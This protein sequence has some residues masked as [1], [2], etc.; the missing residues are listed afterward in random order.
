MARGRKKGG[1]KI[2]PLTD[3]EDIVNKII[4]QANSLNKKIKSFKGEGIAEHKTYLESFLTDDM[5]KWTKSGGI[6]KSKKFYSD[7]HMLWLKKTLSALHKANND[8]FYGT[9]RK[10][11]EELTSSQEKIVSYAQK[12]LSKKGYSNQ[13]IDEVV[14]S[15]GFI[16][17]LI[18]RFNE[19]ATIY[20]SNQVIEDV[21]LTYGTATGFSNDELDR[22]LSNIEMAKN[23]IDEINRQMEEFE[24]FKRLKNKR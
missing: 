18:M 6:S 2:N 14:H 3:K 7:K 20:G 13:F 22:T 19:G 16:A 23:S 10:Y 11:K 1:F 24:E 17:M 12:Y 5:V 15:K 21:A 4:N 8:V 9:V